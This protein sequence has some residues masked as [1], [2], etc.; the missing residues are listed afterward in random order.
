MMATTTAEKR[1]RRL[2]NTNNDDA[3]AT[4]TSTTRQHGQRWWRRRDSSDGDSD[5]DHDDDDGGGGNVTAT[6]VSLLSSWW[7][8]RRNFLPSLAPHIG[9]VASTSAF[10]VITLVQP[11]FQDEG[12]QVWWRRSVMRTDF[13]GEGSRQG[14]R[15]L[16]LLCARC[17]WF[18][19]VCG[20]CCGRIFVVGFCCVL[21]QKNGRDVKNGRGI[22]FGILGWY[23]GFCVWGLFWTEIDFSFKKSPRCTKFTFSPTCKKLSLKQ[24]AHTYKKY[25]S[26]LWTVNTYI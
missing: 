14:K 12:M 4:T 10:G 13:A 1:G 24:K 20:F 15:V 9:S 23:F 25:K 7:F 26:S 8:S 5:D 19:V 6:T 11:S 22:F 21:P 3:T 17:C 18:C 2:N 16:P